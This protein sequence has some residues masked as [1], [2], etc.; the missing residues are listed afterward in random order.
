MIYQVRWS[1]SRRH[2]EP[3]FSYPKGYR[4]YNDNP[5]FASRQRI[6]TPVDELNE[7]PQNWL[8]H[9]GMTLE[10]SVFPT[11]IKFRRKEKVAQDWYR[12]VSYF[13]CISQRIKDKLEELEPGVH[14]FFP[15][16]LLDSDGSEPWGQYYFLQIRNVI[17]SLDVEASPGLY[18][19]ESIT[20]YNTPVKG[21][22]EHP[23]YPPGRY[24]KPGEIKIARV[25]KPE[26]I[27][28]RH[29][30]IEYLRLDEPPNTGLYR[31]METEKDDGSPTVLILPTDPVSAKTTTLYRMTQD[32][33]GF[34]VSGEF[35]D[36]MQAND[37]KG[38]GALAYGCLT[39]EVPEGG[40][41]D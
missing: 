35:W 7:Y 17:F 29:V 27:G 12:G 16:R 37:V 10:A 41:A 8:A 36:W 40:F 5:L 25:H 9:T 34:N 24:I 2:V 13:S 15:T 20:V 33:L 19:N 32:E 6:H 38:L 30:W 22:W 1:H 21:F 31:W 23:N 28:N 11:F 39:T 18:W 26:V 3:D 4:P 14:Q